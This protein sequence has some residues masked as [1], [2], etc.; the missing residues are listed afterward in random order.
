MVGAPSILG[1]CYSSLTSVRLRSFQF[2][3]KPLK[4]LL[5]GSEVRLTET[6]QRD[7]QVQETVLGTVG[8]HAQRTQDREASSLRL[9]S[10]V[11]IVH[12]ERIGRQLCCQRNGLPLPCSED[13]SQRR[14]R[15]LWGL[16]AQPFGS[17][18]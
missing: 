16:N 8:E 9:T 2:C 13:I 15:L 17:R 18:R 3:E 5:I 10:S 14:K 12:Q 11:P 7:T 6:I 1:D 4:Q